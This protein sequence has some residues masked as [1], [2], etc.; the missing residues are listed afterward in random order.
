VKNNTAPQRALDLVFMGT[1][2]FAATV[3]AAL[4]D[5][6]HRITA[7]YTQPPRPA[8]RGP[9]E[10]DG[11]HGRLRSRADETDHLDRGHHR[12][13]PL[14][15][16]HFELR[17]GAEG[18]PAA[19]RAR[20][21]VAHEERGVSEEVRPVGLDVVDV[22]AAVRIL[23]ARAAARGREEGLPAHR[24]EG[25]DGR[26]HAARHCRLRPP[27]ERLRLRTGSGASPG[28][29]PSRLPLHAGSPPSSIHR[30]A[31]RAW[32][33]STKSAPA[34]TIPVRISRTIRFSSIQPL[35][36]AALTIAYSPDTL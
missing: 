32:Y 10:P 35:A 2:A 20:E 22:R 7:V 25:A 27:E 6:E 12:D 34:R 16:A 4:T 30:A 9:R 21:G 29:T 36:A 14:G 1:P 31:S 13:D 11:A 24:G 15:K 19:D 28:G 5:S 23:E 26:A 8:G 33:V 3:L 18:G 17:R